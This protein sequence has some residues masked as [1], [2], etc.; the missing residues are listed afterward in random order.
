MSRPELA[1]IVV[2][3]HAAADVGALAAEWP[4]DRRFELVVVDQTG[5]IEEQPGIRLLRPGTNLGFAAGSNLGAR[6]TDAPILLFL[7]PDTLPEAGALDAIVR[8]FERWPDAAGVVPRLVGF[9][10]A[11]QTGWQLRRLPSPLALL[12]HGLFLSPGGAAG[13][14]AEGTP[15]EQPAAAALALRRAAFEAVDG[16]DERFFPAWF[17]DV[18]LARRLADA[19]LRLLYLPRA[20]VRHRQGG[21]VGTL[22]YR[23]F[24]EAYDRNLLRY[25]DKH[26]GALWS[27]A[28][29]CS[30]GL[31]ALGRLLLLP[32]RKPRRA[33]SRG[34]AA[35]ALLAIA[36]GAPG[37]WR[38]V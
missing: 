30:A 33:A 16:F 25:L 24:L 18:D 7:N 21:S 34:E 17:E 3:W 13:E 10:G 11:A 32:L 22:G 36:A 1:A 8:A 9:D 23:A 31:G 29:R 20:V 6:A 19:G 35:R 2:G 14:P 12:G 38:S 26:H 37:G 4:G 27:L 15:I 5:D 28:F